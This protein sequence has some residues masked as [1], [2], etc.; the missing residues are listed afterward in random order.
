MDEVKQ[1]KK[2]I[3]LDYLKVIV[4]TLIVTYGVL[5]FVQISKVYGTSMLPTYHEGN[6]VLVD[7]VFYKHSEPKRN[8]IVVVD[9]KDANMKETFI[10]KR[11]VGIGG[12]HIEIKDNELYLNDELLE[13]DYINGAMINSEDMV[14]DVPEG[15]VFVM[16]DNRNNSLDSRKLGY[17]D[18]DEDVIGRVFFTVPLT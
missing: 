8:D 4:I 1:S 18:F 5:Y 15:K 2:S 12:D 6:I 17:F 9:Y 14:V 16:G 10:T 13:E 11:V 7:K 3:L